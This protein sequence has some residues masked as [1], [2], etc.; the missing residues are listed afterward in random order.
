M[1]LQDAIAACDSLGAFLRAQAGQPQPPSTQPQPPTPI[2]PTPPTV[3]QN[4]A[5]I[6]DPIVGQLNVVPM[7][8]DDVLAVRLVMPNH[9]STQTASISAVEYQS[10][11]SM[12]I[13]CLSETPGDFSKPV[14]PTGASG[15]A[16]DVTVYF[17]V[18]PSIVNW[19]SPSLE[20]GKT[21]FLNMKNDPE[22]ACRESGVCSMSI[23]YSGVR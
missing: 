19:F 20:Q 11:P 1:N 2:T 12:R 15:K 17:S 4:N 7:S 9:A 14:S 18:L 6:I 13:F 23:Q 3:T 10:S 22:C 8:P 16:I 21:Y 5:R